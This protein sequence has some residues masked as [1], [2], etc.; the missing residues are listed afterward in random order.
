MSCISCFAFSFFATLCGICGLIQYRPN[1]D[2]YNIWNIS[3]CLTIFGGMSIIIITIYWIYHY[4]NTKEEY[5][6]LV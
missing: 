5:I 3:I 4:C 1:T 6:S 2:T